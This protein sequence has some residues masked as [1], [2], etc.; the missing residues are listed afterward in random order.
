MALYSCGWRQHV[1]RHVQQMHACRKLKVYKGT[2]EMMDRLRQ[3]ALEGY[4]FLQDSLASLPAISSDEVKPLDDAYLSFLTASVKVQDNSTTGKPLGAF[5]YSEE[6]VRETRQQLL[7]DLSGDSGEGGS[8]LGRWLFMVASAFE[9][10]V[11]AV[12]RLE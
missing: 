12:G 3:D 10:F 1:V 4:I 9:S 5:W 8:A 6:Q 11:S 7:E 2:K